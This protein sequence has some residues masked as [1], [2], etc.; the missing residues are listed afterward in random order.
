[1]AAQDER[2]QQP[3]HAT[4]AVAEGMNGLELHVRQRGLHQRWHLIRQHMQEPLEVAQQRIQSVR[5]GR[6]EVRQ[7]GRR[8]TDPD[9][10]LAELARLLAGAA[11]AT[12]QQRVHFPDQAQGQRE[13]VLAQAPE[14]VVERGDVV[15]H[16]LHVVQRHARRFFQLEQQQVRQR[17]LGALD[18]RRQQR[19]LPHVL[20]E[21]QFG[22]GQHQGD[23]V[24]PAQCLVGPFLARN[25]V[26]RA[27]VQRRIGRQRRGDERL[28]A[29]AGQ[30]AGDVTAGGARRHDLFLAAGNPQV[31]E[32]L[33]AFL[34]LNEADIPRKE[35]PR[36]QTT[37]AIE[38]FRPE[39]MPS[40][41]TR[42]PFFRRPISRSFESTIGTEAGPMLPCSPKMVMTFFG[43]MPMAL[44]KAAVW[45]LLTWWITYWSSSSTAQ[46]SAWR[47][48][49]KVFC[50][51]LMPSSSSMRVSV[52]MPSRLPRQ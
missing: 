21:E 7:R 50:A 38:Q 2:D 5:W 44:V 10:A 16:L 52:I 47:A 28:V 35:S 36:Y 1:L 43:S 42:S 37:S 32:R 33:A 48:A 6:H 40:S 46:P 17:G 24:Q 51:S 13:V 29:A 9:L 14:A 18:L 27:E 31:K 8:T 41:A 11:P 15:G 3:S 19:F 20:V 39:P 22:V 45:T 30:G 49:A 4:I 12:Q 34:F 23:A 26:E 25:Q